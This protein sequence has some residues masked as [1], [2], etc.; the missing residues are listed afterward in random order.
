MRFG[1]LKKA[2]GGHCFHLDDDDDDVIKE[3]TSW[4]RQQ[5]K[6]IYQKGIRCHN[7]DKV[8]R[9]HPHTITNCV[10][11]P[12]ESAQITVKANETEQISPQVY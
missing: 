5:P 7:S 4:L 11:M 1:E 2:L 8:R 12:A 10:V 6:A 3:E 9:R